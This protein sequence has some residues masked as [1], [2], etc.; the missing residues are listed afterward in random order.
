MLKDT[1]RIQGD[2]FEDSGSVGKG[3]NPY[4]WLML[5]FSEHYL[6]WRRQFGKLSVE[7]SFLRLRH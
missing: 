5:N 1:F 3:H 6:M 2:S 7:A 4:K